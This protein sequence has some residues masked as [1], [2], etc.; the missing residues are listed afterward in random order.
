MSTSWVNKELDGHVAHLIWGQV[1]DQITNGL[2]KFHNPLQLCNMSWLL[3]LDKNLQAR[4]QVSQEHFQF[5]GTDTRWFKPKWP[6][7][8]LMTETPSRC[9]LFFGVVLTLALGSV[10]VHFSFII[11]KGSAFFSLYIIWKVWHCRQTASLMLIRQP[12]M[13]SIL[14]TSFV[15]FDCFQMWGTVP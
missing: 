10:C 11:F 3:I 14:C 1:H 8:M 15:V 12:V 7:Y 6:S 2:L 9:S 5:N 4:N 13:N